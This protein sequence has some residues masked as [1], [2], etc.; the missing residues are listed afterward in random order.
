MSLN[1]TFI[2]V[3][4]LEYISYGFWRTKSMIIFSNDELHISWVNTLNTEWWQAKCVRKKEGIYQ[5]K[6]DT[7]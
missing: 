4:K 6:K 1:V 2:L 3:Q 5:E 7:S